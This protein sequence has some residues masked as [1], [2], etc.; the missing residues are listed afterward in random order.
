MREYFRVKKSSR[1]LQTLQILYLF[2]RAPASQPSVLSPRSNVAKAGAAQVEDPVPNDCTVVLLADNYLLE[3]PLEA[4]ESLRADVIDSISRDVSL[5]M[6]HHRL[7]VE[8]PGVYLT[9]KL[10]LN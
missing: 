3:L 6:M 2:S 7:T 4:L 1:A 8:T 9:W 5:Q 10:K